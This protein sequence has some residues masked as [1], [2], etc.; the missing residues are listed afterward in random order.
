MLNESGSLHTCQLNPQIYPF[1]FTLSA[2]VLRN[3]IGLS[4]IGLTSFEAL[5][6]CDFWQAP[7]DGLGSLESITGGGSSSGEGFGGSVG[8]V[9]S[10]GGDRQ[11]CVSTRFQGGGIIGLALVGWQ[12]AGEAGERQVTGVPRLTS[13]SWKNLLLVWQSCSVGLLPLAR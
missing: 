5:L 1:S 2:S 12:G 11:S 9:S 3:F 8:R 13:A 7:I 6:R 10:L 4:K